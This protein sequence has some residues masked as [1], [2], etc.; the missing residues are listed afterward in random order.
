[1]ANN[2]MESPLS[3]LTIREMHIESAVTSSCASSSMANMEISINIMSWQEHGTTR[4]LTLCCYL[5][6]FICHLG[7]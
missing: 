2:Y 5:K 1:M 3:S 4:I 6:R 7:K